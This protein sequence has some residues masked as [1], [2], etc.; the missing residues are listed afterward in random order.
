MSEAVFH[1]VSW[2]YFEINQ[3]LTKSWSN[4]LAL[5]NM[6]FIFVTDDEFQKVR[7]SLKVGRLSK[8]SVKLVTLLVH[9]RLQKNAKESKTST[10][11]PAAH[12]CDPFDGIIHSML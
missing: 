2:W 6:V 7:G 12:V 1:V 9:L 5:R 3:G 10:R 4:A 8:R 11:T